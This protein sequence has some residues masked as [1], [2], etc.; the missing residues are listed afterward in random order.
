MSCNPRRTHNRQVFLP[1]AVALFHTALNR[2]SIIALYNPQNTHL[3]SVLDFMVHAAFRGSTRYILP[4]LFL[5][6]SGFLIDWQ[7]NLLRSSYICP[8]ATGAVRLIPRLQWVGLVFDCVLVFLLYTLFDAR[9]TS[10][11]D[12]SPSAPGYDNHLLIVGSAFCVSCCLPVHRS[13][14]EY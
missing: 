10:E 11:R 9:W 5:C 6:A 14:A 1:L 8:I 13:S 2:R 12:R 3:R 7:A 4:A